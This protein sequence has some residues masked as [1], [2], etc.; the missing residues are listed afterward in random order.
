MAG[1]EKDFKGRRDNNAP[2][3]RRDLVDA[4][5]AAGVAADMAEEIRLR[6]QAEDERN[7]ETRL[8]GEASTGTSPSGAVGLSENASRLYD[9]TDPINDKVIREA[10]SRCQD[11][12]QRMSGLEQR[13]IENERYYRQQCYYTKD[14]DERKSLPERGSAYLLNAIINKTADMMDNYPQPTILPREESDEQAADVLSKIVPVVLER[15]NFVKTYYECS[16]E[17]IKDGFSVYG[18]F[19]NPVKDNIGEVE[20]R[21][22]DALNMRWEPGI[23]DIQDSKEIFVLSEYDTD[24]LKD[25]Y[26]DIL[27]NIQGGSDMGELSHY[28]SDDDLQH[29]KKS[30]VYDW[31]YKKTIPRNIAGQVFPVTVLHYAKFCEG[32]LL[33]ASENDPSLRERGWYDS[34]DYPFVIDT[35]YPIKDTPYGFGLIDMMREPQEYIDKI[36]HAIMLNA[37][38]NARPR[39]FVKE[40]SDVSEKEYADF[41]NLFISYNGDPD[42]IKPVAAAQLASIYVQILEDKKE[43]LK[44]NA[45]NR[46]FSQGSTT[47]SVTAA[48]AIAA[49][50]EASSKTSRMSNLVSYQAFKQVVK[51]VIERIEQFYTIPRTFRIIE[52]NQTSYQ[53]VGV[54]QSNASVQGQIDLVPGSRFDETL[55]QFVGGRVPVY[56][57]SVGAEK[58][59]PYSRVVQN[60]IAKELYQ[61]GA[62]NPQLADQALPMLEMMD[63][64]GKDK[65]IKTV[66]ENQQ[67]A[68]TIQV[69]QQRM[70]QMAEIIGNATGD[71]RLMDALSGN[72][73]EAAGATPNAGNSGGSLSVNQLGEA[74]RDTSSQADQMAEET[75]NRAQVG[76]TQ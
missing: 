54:G 8:S 68:A 45:G 49:L 24:T 4:N 18:V 27:R 17:K 25:M 41:N 10:Q 23:T 71:T 61:E 21:R 67:L 57:I 42:N 69:M 7:L 55:G 31:Y 70:Q 56:D 3:Y 74:T 58:A 1:K 32:K 65:V 60:E 44:E 28:D 50:Q 48:S 43:E 33:Y 51:M 2:V 36:D 14:P 73:D 35:L 16:M 6:Q 59:S 34:P 22:I 62:F 29:E 39:W 52:N 47:G 20:V 66:S 75:R 46:D 37:L 9:I 30:I 19:W 63:F 72:T 38:A 13:L 76:G 40:G 5:E 12:W 53:T 15:N 26:P 11:Y 64:D